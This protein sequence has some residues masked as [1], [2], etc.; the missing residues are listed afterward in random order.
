MVRSATSSEEILRNGNAPANA[1]VVTAGPN[2]NGGGCFPAANTMDFISYLSL[3]TCLPL[4]I[5]VFSLVHRGGLLRHPKW[6][7][8]RFFQMQL[9][10][11]C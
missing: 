6:R 11:C 2:P 1:R 9:D 7:S 8:R 4:N 5:V 10:A 3:T